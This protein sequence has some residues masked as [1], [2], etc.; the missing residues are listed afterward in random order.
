M[1]INGKR[2][3]GGGEVELDIGRGVNE[4]MREKRGAAE[5][6]EGGK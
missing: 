5:M 4:E 1:K 3:E 6:T 2:H